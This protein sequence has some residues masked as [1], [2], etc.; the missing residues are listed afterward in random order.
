MKI[1]Y[2]YSSLFNKLIKIDIIMKKFNEVNLL[3]DR[4]STCLVHMN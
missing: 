2:S 1:I 3:L 4:H